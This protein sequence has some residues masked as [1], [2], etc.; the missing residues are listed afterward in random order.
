M[1]LVG[2]IIV[3]DEQFGLA[4]SDFKWLYPQTSIVRPSEDSV[5]K[6]GIFHVE[7]IHSGFPSVGVMDCVY[8]PLVPVTAEDVRND[9]RVDDFLQQNAGAFCSFR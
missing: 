4:K 5:S 2:R 1:V 9:D 8:S 7:H 6:S 3:P